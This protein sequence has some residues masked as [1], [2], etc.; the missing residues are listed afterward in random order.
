VLRIVLISLSLSLL[1]R[2]SIPPSVRRHIASISTRS[3][4]ARPR[5]TRSTRTSRP[6]STLRTLR[7]AS[8]TPRP[9]S[10]RHARRTRTPR[11]ASP[12]LPP[13]DAIPSATP[14]RASRTASAR[15]TWSSRAPPVPRTSLACRVMAAVAMASFSFRGD[16]QARRRNRVSQP[17]EPR[18][19][20]PGWHQRTPF[21]ADD[22][23]HT[24]APALQT[25]SLQTNS[26]RHDG[27]MQFTAMPPGKSFHNVEQLSGGERT[28]AALALLFAIQSYVVLHVP[29]A[30]PSCR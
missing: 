17:R 13:S 5:S 29:A 21:L 4:S 14:S 22:T 9:S 19:S 1:C 18:G 23:I 8:R 12:R 2:A 30:R 25:N 20:V 10:T 27:G 11:R 15:F 26:W 16:A 7:S 3:T 24:S 6:A 28:V